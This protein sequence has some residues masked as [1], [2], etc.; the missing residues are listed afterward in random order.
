MYV[1]TG[2]TGNTG[3]GIAERLLAQRHIVRAIGRNEQRL[4]SITAKGAEPF[5]C[6]LTDTDEL[7]RAFSGALAVYVLIPTPPAAT[8]DFLTYQEQ[9]GDSLASAIEAAGVQHVV[10]LSSI[11]ADKSD[12]TGPIVG[13]HNLEQKLNRI[14]GLD[15]L[16]LRAAYFMENTFAQIGMIRSTGH[17][18]GTLRPDLK[19]PMIATRDISAAVAAELLNSDFSGKHTRE[20]LGPRDISMTKV[21]TI[22]GKVI[23]QSG[24][25]YVQ[26]SDDEARPI[27][28]QFGFSL[29][30]ADL[31]LEMASAMN[32]GHMAF[33]EPR[34]AKNTAAT[35]YETFAAEEFLPRFRQSQPLAA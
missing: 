17:A 4:R 24:L 2:A 12:G 8:S 22:L 26:V 32:T 10:S 27:L 3:R 9:I 15:V 18:S 31:I 13:L 23:G 25:K 16:H 11:G 6:D 7:T 30:L 28:L 1:I 29:D 5:V 20:L 33:L 34:T 21:A 14:T 19:I 35:S